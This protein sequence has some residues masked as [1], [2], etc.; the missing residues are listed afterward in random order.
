MHYGEYTTTSRRRQKQFQFINWYVDRNKPLNRLDIAR[1]FGIKLNGATVVLRL[2]QEAHPDVI[3]YDY[4]KR[5]YMPAKKSEPVQ[6]E[7]PLEPET[8]AEDYGGSC[9]RPEPDTV[10]AEEY[11]KSRCQEEQTAR[12]RD[13][14]RVQELLDR[15]ADRLDEIVNDLRTY[16]SQVMQATDKSRIINLTQKPYNLA[17]RLEAAV[18]AIRS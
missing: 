2:Y 1:K 17:D 13:R 18:Q 8:T 15:F 9:T 10:S 14:Q 6:A 7:L 12:T 5:A 11:W 4:T 16:N 3:A